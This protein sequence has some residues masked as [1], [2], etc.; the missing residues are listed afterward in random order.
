MTTQEKRPIVFLMIDIITFSVYYTILL[1]LYNGTVS[2]IGELP[3]WG[4]AI[5]TLMPT[6]IIARITLYIIYS[7]LNTAITK[8]KEDKFVMD[9]FGE[10]IRLRATRNFSNTFMICFALT[11]GLL[12]LG[13]SI[14]SMFKILFFSVLVA[15]MV[16]NLSE[17]YYSRK[18]I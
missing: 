6:M 2:S 14:S 5:L 12:V 13:I 18:G 11:M 16:Q 8:Q 7:I 15:F 10:L 9:E 17:F 1:E 3:F 4:A